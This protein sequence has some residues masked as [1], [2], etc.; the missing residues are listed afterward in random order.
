MTDAA[1][2]LVLTSALLHACWNLLAKRAGGGVLFVWLFTTISSIL[3]APLAIAIVVWGER[4][5]TPVDAI[6][7]SGSAA[8]HL[9]YFVSLQR[10]YRDGDLSVV[11]PL[12]RGTG[13]TFASIAAIV[14]LGERPTTQAIAGA[15]AVIG[16]VLFLTAGGGSSQPDKR[17]RGIA[18]GFA[19]GLTIASYTVWDKFAVS[20]YDVSPILLQVVG[21]FGVS[22]VLTPIAIRN[23][24]AVRSH[25]QEHRG[26][27]IIVSILEPA[28]YTL[29]LFAMSFTDLFYVASAREVSILVGTL[30]GAYLLKEGLA[31]RRVIAAAT[32]VAGLIALATG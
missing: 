15:V 29:V 4:S 21:N 18:W 20:R 24:S 16:G 25:W 14:W 1:L 10:A 8:L 32:I 13:P 6:F 11:Y 27:T 30:F 9:V 17:S 19:C 31:A 28:A 3:Y 26:K 22:L 12:A 2:G 5:L 7:M 23:W